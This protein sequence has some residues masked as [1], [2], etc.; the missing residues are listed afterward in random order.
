MEAGASWKP[1]SATTEQDPSDPG[2]A[3]PSRLDPQ[4]AGP[5]LCLCRCTPSA[6]GS[7]WYMRGSL[8]GQHGDAPAP[9]T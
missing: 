8:G 6:H 9:V 5:H 7:A 1:A 4:K 2:R 3:I